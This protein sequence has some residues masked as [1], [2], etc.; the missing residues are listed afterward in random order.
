MLLELDA[1]VEVV[2][3]VLHKCARV[4]HG[5]TGEVL[6]ELHGVLFVL[7]LVA[8]AQ[9]NAQVLLVEWEIV[10]LEPILEAAG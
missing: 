1:R 6:A 2:L 8:S 3:R 9:V 4:D 5:L 10:Q 7:Q